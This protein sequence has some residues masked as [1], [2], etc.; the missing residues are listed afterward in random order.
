LQ[1]LWPAGLEAA[2]LEHTTMAVSGLP[3]FPQN[4]ASEAFSCPHEAQSI[5]AQY[6]GQEDR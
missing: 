2:Q 1:K 4:R 5:A 3:Q 6:Y